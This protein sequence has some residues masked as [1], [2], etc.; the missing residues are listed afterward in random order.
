MRKSLTVLGAFLRRDWRIDLSYRAAFGAS[1]V[2]SILS[3]AVFYFLSEVIDEDAIEQAGTTGD[4]FAFVA[5]GLAIF[6]IVQSSMISFSRKLREEQ[7]TGTFETLMSTPASP[8]LVILG[9]AC[10]EILRAVI[11]AVLLLAAAVI[12]FGLEFEID[13]GSGGVILVALIGTLTLFASIGVAIGA[14]TVL[15]KRVA[16]VIGLVLAA[17]SLLSGVYFPIEVLPAPF[18]LIA[19]SLPITWALDVLRAALLGGQVDAA[20]LVGLLLSAAL[21]LPL[22]LQGFRASVARARRTGTLAEY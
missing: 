17:V 5:V 20:Q 19:E 10:Y 9:S 6:T 11:D 21:L 2:S 3:L 15:F 14:I 7:T 18:Q 8:A 16:A 1:L 22:T 12:L 13:P 4:Y